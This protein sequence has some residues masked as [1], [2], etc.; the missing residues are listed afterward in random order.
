MIFRDH[1]EFADGDIL[2]IQAGDAMYCT[3]RKD[4]AEVYTTVEVGNV[5]HIK[6]PSRWNVYAEDYDGTDF[7]VYCW[8]PAVLVHELIKSKGGIIDGEIP[9]L[10]VDTYNQTVQY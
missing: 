10:A 4:F 8:V 9:P 6:L 3:P 1:V 2:S 5:N 7:M